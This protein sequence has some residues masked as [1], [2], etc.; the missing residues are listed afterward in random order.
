MQ[1]VSWLGIRVSMYFR[2]KREAWICGPNWNVP[3]YE[4]YFNQLPRGQYFFRFV[5]TK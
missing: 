3:S 5:F 2:G 1:L 4:Y